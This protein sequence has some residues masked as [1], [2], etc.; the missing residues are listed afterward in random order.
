MRRKTYATPES[1]RRYRMEKYKQNVSSFSVKWIYNSKFETIQN[2]IVEHTGLPLEAINIM[3]RKRTV[4]KYRQ[5]GMYLSKEY[6]DTSLAMIGLVWGNKN[7]ATV[8][9]A[10][11]TVMNLCETDSNYRNEVEGLKREVE[12]KLMYKLKKVYE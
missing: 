12:S 9:H 6:I 4:I 11:K 1:L 8:L 5:I 2:I 10:H 3:S 7:H